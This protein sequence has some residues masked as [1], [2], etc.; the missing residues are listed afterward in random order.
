MRLFR[1]STLLFATAPLA[2]AAASGAPEMPE[3]FPT[4]PS[5]Q[6]IAPP[7]SVAGSSTYYRSNPVWNGREFGVAYSGTDNRLHF[8]RVYADGT[9][10]APPL[11]LTSRGTY[12]PPSLVWN[13]SGYGVAWM[14]T[15]AASVNYQ[16]YFARLNPD[17]S[18]IGSELKVSVAGA[19]ETASAYSPALAWSGAGYAVV[20]TDYRNGATTGYDIYATLLDSAGAIAG[21]GALHDQVVSTATNNQY[22]PTLAWSAGAGLYVAIWQDLRSNTKYELYESYIT[23]AGTVGGN[24]SAVSGASNSYA[25]AVADTGNGLGLVWYDYRDANYEIYFARLNANGSKVG[26]DLRL[27]NDTANSYYPRIVWTGG[28][29]GVVWYDYRSGIET[30]FQRVSQAGAA[31]GG[32]TQVTFSGD[33]E[34]PDLAFGSKGYLLTGIYNG[35]PGPVLLQAWGCAADSTPPS[36]PG[37]FLAYNITGTTAS[38]SWS[39]SSDYESDLA[40]YQVYRNNTL[41]GKTSSEYFNDSGLPLSSTNNYMIQPVNAWQ[42]QNTACTGSLYVKTNSSLTLTMNKAT[43]RDAG[44][45]WTDAG[46]NNYNLFRGNRPQVM[47]QIGATPNLSSTDPNALTSPISYFYSVD[48]P[49]P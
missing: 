3:V 26:A 42:L 18:M 15:S 45:N 13:G 5:P 22:S 33:T 34:I 16:I 49:G 25:P 43:T 17:G 46:F 4:C 35:G 7:Q 47:S 1:L 9:V 37:N 41:V 6:P 21:G 11:T 14:E 24:T 32:N 27:T 12:Y 28:E 31:V 8:V 2:L 40:Y 36:C 44:L 10:A 38:V 23:P 20:W 39:P 30:W 29:F 19:L 48:N